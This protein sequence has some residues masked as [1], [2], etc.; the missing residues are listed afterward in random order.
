MPTRRKPAP[1]DPQPTDDDAPTPSAAAEEEEPEAAE[2]EIDEAVIASADDD[3]EEE[4]EEEIGALD[5]DDDD[6]LDEDDE[7][8]P[9]KPVVARPAA[10]PA[11]GRPPSAKEEPAAD[12]VLGP[13]DEDQGVGDSAARLYGQRVEDIS[14]RVLDA[15]SRRH[16]RVPACFGLVS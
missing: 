3:T 1:S 10:R 4:E 8:A 12:A 7:V 13:F 5:D 16:S 14:H 11:P 9:P 15:R 6:D 2:P